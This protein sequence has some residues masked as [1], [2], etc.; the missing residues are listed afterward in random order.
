LAKSA[1]GSEEEIMTSLLGNYI[2]NEI[3][4]IIKPNDEGTFTVLAYNFTKN[5][6]ERNFNFYSIIL[7][8]REEIKKVSEEE[9]N[10]F[11]KNLGKVTSRSSED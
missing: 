3:P 10:S 5:E 6:F 11:I 9:L 4:V 8:G 7:W 2:V 1:T